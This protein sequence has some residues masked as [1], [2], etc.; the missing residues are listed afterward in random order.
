MMMAVTL[1]CFVMRMNTIKN[2]AEILLAGQ[3][4]SGH[5]DTFFNI[6]LVLRPASNLQNKDR[7]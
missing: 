3:R 1:S 2:D 4:S 5:A 7:L 6:L